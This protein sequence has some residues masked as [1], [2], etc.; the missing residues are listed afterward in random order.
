MDYEAHFRACVAGVRAEGRYRVFADLA[1]QV[2][3]VA[4]GGVARAGRGR[5]RGG[6]LVLERLSGPGASRGGA[7]GGVRGGAAATAPGPA[8][9]ATSRARRGCMCSSRPR[10]RALHGKP[11]ALLF[12]SGYVANE[13]AIGTHRAAAA[14]LPDPVGRA[15]PRL[16]DRRA[17]RR[18][19][20]EA[21]LPPQRPGPS[22]AAAGGA[23]AGAAEAGGVRGRLLDGR[24]FRPG[25]RGLRAGAALWRAD[26]SRRGARGRHVRRARAPGSPSATA[27]WPRSTWSR[28]RWARR[29]A[30]WAATSPA[31]RPWSTRCAATRRASSSPPPCRRRWSAGP[32]RR[33]GCWPARP[34]W[35][36]ARRSRSGRR[37]LKR[38]LRGG[39]ACR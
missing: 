12:T 20:R 22:R 10:W 37:R 2:G 25:G 36:C 5:A 16:D 8:A 15:Q 33:C 21:D 29:S 11:A 3:R 4:A 14:G 24:R 34:G 38:R 39:R 19:L 26:L 28:A 27:S 23:A 17:P 30:A 35:P 7:G 18:G 9:R 1:R 32:W 31:G 13:A 6:G